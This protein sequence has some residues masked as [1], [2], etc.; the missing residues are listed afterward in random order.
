MSQQEV[1]ARGSHAN[2][3]AVYRQITDDMD[4]T[5]KKVRAELPDPISRKRGSMLLHRFPRDD[6]VN[7][8]LI[9]KL[10]QSTSNI[11]AA[12]LLVER[13]LLY[14]WGALRRMLNETIQD[15]IFLLVVDQS[16]PTA[17]LRRRYLDHF[18]SEDIDKHGNVSHHNVRGVTRAEI[19][20]V[21]TEAFS[22]TGAPG[23]GTELAEAIRGLHRLDSGSVHGK[24]SSIMAYLFDA[25]NSE[26]QTDGIEDEMLVEP[27]NNTFW[28]LTYL[29][30]ELFAAA[31][32]RWLAA[33]IGCKR[34]NWHT[35][36]A[37]RPAWIFDGGRLPISGRVVKCMLLTSIPALSRLACERG[38]GLVTSLPMLEVVLNAWVTLTKLTRWRSNSSTMRA[39][40]ASERVSRSIL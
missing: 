14:E 8:A 29:V 1:G 38:S 6:D 28:I 39:K 30:T 34:S 25:N 36:W 19:R 22:R 11:R 13:C 24:A 5:I 3:E 17:D 27:E 12:K 18:F 15:V 2:L 23:N 10:V 31:G 40:S 20:S 33:T 21:V 4:L 7:L 9:L 32:A 26:F 16:G 37:R 35:G